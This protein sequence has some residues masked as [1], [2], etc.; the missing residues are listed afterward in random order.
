MVVFQ[1]KNKM[2]FI[3]SI[4]LFKLIIEIVYI[5]SISPLYSYS[6]LVYDPNVYAFLFSNLLLLPILYFINIHTKKPSL[7]L[8]LFLLLFIY[9][10]L[11]SYYWMTSMSSVYFFYVS[12]SVLSILFIVKLP[13]IKIN[14]LKINSKFIINALFV[15]YVVSSTY[16]IFKKRRY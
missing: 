15:F 12:L 2:K 11:S 6:G 16:L 4:Y 8:F 14:P 10:P 9:I 3:F 13:N 1:M 5:I 7:H